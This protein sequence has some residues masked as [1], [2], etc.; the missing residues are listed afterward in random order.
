MQRPPKP[1]FLQKKLKGTHYRRFG[2]TTTYTVAPC[3]DDAEEF[4]GLAT[5]RFS[6]HADVGTSVD[7]A[8]TDFKAV[9]FRHAWNHRTLADA[10]GNTFS[11][12]CVL[13][14]CRVEI[15]DTYV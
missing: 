10:S 15:I 8:F 7:G 13:T 9:Q 3:K 2:A 5:N 14:L 4:K 6:S 12:V 11:K 1:F